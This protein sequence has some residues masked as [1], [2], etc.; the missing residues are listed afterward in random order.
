MAYF[1]MY[2]GR[3]QIGKTI[4]IY[5]AAVDTIY[6][7]K[8]GVAV[9]VGTTDAT[10]KLTVNKSYLRNGTY[11]LYSSVAKDPNN[12]SN[13]YSK[14]V[15]VSG[16]TEEIWLMPTTSD[17]MIYWYGNY[18]GRSWTDEGYYNGTNQPITGRITNGNL[19]INTNNI[20]MLSSS[21]P[22]FNGNTDYDRPWYGLSNKISLNNITKGHLIKKYKTATIGTYNPNFQ[23]AIGD[24]KYFSNA[25][26][27][28]YP[29]YKPVYPNPNHDDTIEYLVSTQSAISGEKYVYIRNWDNGDGGFTWYAIWL[30]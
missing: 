18:I 7:M 1:K 5:S 19:I 24:D 15:T 9:T 26:S 6:Y 29:G 25:V 16:G 14:S 28:C 27:I 4:D 17:K 20:Y 2:G 11:T 13:A 22:N 12:L 21:N 23:V 30:E 10:G 8:N 3:I